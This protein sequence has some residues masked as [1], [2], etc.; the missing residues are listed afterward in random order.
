MSGCCGCW[1]V[2]GPGVA[3]T[4]EG[5]MAG[6]KP[7][8]PIPGHGA[9]PWGQGGDFIIAQVGLALRS[10]AG[11]GC[12]RAGISLGQGLMAPGGWDGV[13]SYGQGRRSPGD[14]GRDIK[15]C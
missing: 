14:L 5:G 15:T 1:K 8:S 11:Q 2:P 7:G 13:L 6:T 12:G 3:G 4:P 10:L 9:S